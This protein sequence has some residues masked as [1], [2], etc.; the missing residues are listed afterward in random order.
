MSNAI[1]GG[2]LCGQ[3][4]YGVEEQPKLN[5]VCHCASC[6]RHS[7]SAFSAAALVPRDKITIA[8]ETR[9]YAETSDAGNE[10]KR[11]FCPNC[12]PSLYSEAAACPGDLVLQAGTIDDPH[13]FKPRANFWT[14][15]AMPWVPIDPECKNFPQDAG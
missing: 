10:I 13:W 11:A 7:G 1:T 6:R 9:V 3:V 5:I 8:G 4:R 12:D 14:D 15:S 2:C